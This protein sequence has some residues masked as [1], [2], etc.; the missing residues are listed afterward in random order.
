MPSNINWTFLND[1][2]ILKKV[3]SN[4]RFY[5]QNVVKLLHLYKLNYVCVENISMLCQ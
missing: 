2:G 3:A 1:I 4:I 5:S